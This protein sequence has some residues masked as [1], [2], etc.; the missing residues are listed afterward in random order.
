MNTENIYY[1][2]VYK[3]E[4]GT[5]YY[6]GKGKGSRAFITSRKIVSP[7]RD[8]TNIFFACE[9]VSETE[10]FEVE[11]ALISL[12]GRKDL[13]TGILRN[14]TDGGEGVS[15][16]VVSE[17]TRRKMSETRKNQP[18]SDESRQK[19]SRAKKGRPRTEETKRRISV[20]LTGRPKS[21]ESRKKLSETRKGNNNASKLTD[22]Q[23]L[24]I[25]QRRKNGESTLKLATEFGVTQRTIYNC[26]KPQF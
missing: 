17:E 13:G 26:C 18:L 23:R 1:C 2:Y 25:V 21:E 24:E 9:G 7:P 15:G 3:R 11:V 8:R 12:L 10:A 20:T 14:R 4:D 22:V 19:M 5:P 6:I 16:V